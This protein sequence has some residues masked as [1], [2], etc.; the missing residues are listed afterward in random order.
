MV[1]PNI[2]EELNFLSE[3]SS[4]PS[5]PAVRP[6]DKSSTPG[7]GFMSSYLKFLQGERDGSPPPTARGARKQAWSRTPKMATTPEAKTA[8]TNGVAAA[9]VPQ[10]VPVTRLSQVLFDF[11][12]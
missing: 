11:S 5:A 1:V 6:L 10:P 4:R 12:L 3:S 9:V 7:A 2:E 8:D